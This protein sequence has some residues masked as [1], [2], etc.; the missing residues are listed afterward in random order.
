[1]RPITGGLNSIIEMQCLFTHKMIAHFGFREEIYQNLA[2]R[3]RKYD[4]YY[5]F[6]KSA[7]PTDHLVSYGFYNDDVATAMKINPCVWDCRTLKDLVIH[8][9]FPNTPFKYRQDGPYK[10]EG[11]KEMVYRIYANHKGFSIIFNWL[12]TYALLQLTS[13]VCLIMTWHQQPFYF[14][15]L[16]FLLSLVIVWLNPVSSFVASIG[17]GH[18]SYVNIVM[19]LALGLT[20]FYPNPGVPLAS[21]MIAIIMTYVFR[22]LGWSRMPFNDLRNKTHPKYQEFFDRY[23]KAFREVFSDSY[24][25]FSTR[26]KSI[27]ER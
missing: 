3:I 26:G 8:F 18:N 1:V 21:L 19:T 6:S 14:P 12:L 9:I 11:V 17:F 25:K 22:Q 15:T 4:R 7:N 27:V 24:A 20:V 5:R 10:V 16:A 2:E 23:C 13:Y